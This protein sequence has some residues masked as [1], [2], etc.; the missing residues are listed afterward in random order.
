M[1]RQSLVNALDFFGDSSSLAVEN[2]CQTKIK[3][4]KQK[5]SERP[6]AEPEQD[7]TLVSGMKNETSDVTSGREDGKVV[8]LQLFS[9]CTPLHEEVVK[10]SYA[11]AGIKKRKKKHLNKETRELLRRQEVGVLSSS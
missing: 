6:V 1:K 10:G 2:T 7:V 11:A 8:P 4:G 5:H 3:L 9:G